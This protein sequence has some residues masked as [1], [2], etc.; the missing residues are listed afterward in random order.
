MIT[1][2]RTIVSDKDSFEL[3]EDPNP[4]LP[5]LDITDPDDIDFDSTDF[6]KTDFGVIN[7]A[8]LN[9]DL[10]N[11]KLAQPNTEN[12][13]SDLFDLPNE[14]DFQKFTENSQ[15]KEKLKRRNTT[16]IFEDVN[17]NVKNVVY[18]Y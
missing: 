2:K 13:S 12:S 1:E 5:G 8:F 11:V 6:D 14:E 17:K 4:Y 16:D 10:S 18:H 3:N 15:P 9:K 7:P